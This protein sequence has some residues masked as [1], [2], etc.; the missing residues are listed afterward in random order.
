MISSNAKLEVVSSDG[1]GQNNLQAQD[2]SQLLFPLDRSARVI[3]ITVHPDRALEACHARKIRKC[4]QLTKVVRRK[5]TV[6]R[7]MT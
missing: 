2:G 5:N 1:H 6:L 3:E 7:I 4:G